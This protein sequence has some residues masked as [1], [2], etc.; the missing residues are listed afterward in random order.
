MG[1]VP[2]VCRCIYIYIWLH[3]IRM[4]LHNMLTMVYVKT[5]VLSTRVPPS[6]TLVSCKKQTL[7][8][9]SCNL[10]DWASCATFIEIWI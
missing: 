6:G 7:G 5:Y 4:K 8:F 1:V 3:K 9:S 2:R 10:V